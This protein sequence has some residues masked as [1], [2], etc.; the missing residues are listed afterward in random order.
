MFGWLAATAL[1]LATAGTAPEADILASGRTLVVNGVDALT[2]KTPAGGFT[3]E[4][5]I[6]VIAKALA[7][8]KKGQTVVV[9]SD[10]GLR[11]ALQGKTVATVTEAEAK[12]QGVTPAQLAELWAISINKALYVPP[13]VLPGQPIELVVG[14]LQRI[15]VVGSMSRL[16]EVKVEPSG[17]VEVTRQGFDMVLRP[18]KRGDGQIV[19]S[20]GGAFKSVL[21]SILTPAALF[22]QQFTVEVTGNPA[23]QG[24][25]LE[26]IQ[27]AMST[28]VDAE[29]KA[30]IRYTV[31][32]QSDL[33]SG[34][35]RTVQVQAEVEAPG[36][37]PV[38]G[39][40][41]VVVRNSGGGVVYDD[42]LWYSNDPENLLGPGQLYFA[43]MVTGMPTRLLW[44]HYNKTSA[45]LAVQYTL[46]NRSDSQARIWL[47]SGDGEPSADP[48]KVG[49]DAGQKYFAN[50]LG[51]QGSVLTLPSRSATPLSLRRLS[52]GQ[53]SSGLA[54][55]QLLEGGSDDVVLIGNAVNPSEIPD[56][57][58]PQ[59]FG[60]KPWLVRRSIANDRFGFPVVGQERLVFSNPAK[61]IGF[62][63][64]VGGRH[65]FIRLGE[66]GIPSAL[67][68]TPL[69]GNFG[70]QYVVE[71]RLENPT[72]KAQT[73]EIEFE[74]SAGYSGAVFRVNGKILP[75]RILQSKESV[76]LHEVKLPAG[77]AEP[78]RIDTIPL[79]GAHYPATITVRP[80]GTS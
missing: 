68:G 29:P 40:V 4:E 75:G 78:L 42:V 27:G 65:Q 72:S 16:A 36:F 30:L 63:Y 11:V 69:S 70:V 13:L 76:V 79:S 2:L 47:T 80:K 58:K 44:H 34:K 48:T 57:W 17:L 31:P 74:A 60:S 38:K 32:E 43:R 39:Q 56:E 18:L 15:R 35:I 8:F 14:Q 26:S 59:E 67:G 61:Q 19:V 45:P 28:M 53:T 21:F 7:P 37:A 6:Q 41:T 66:K 73:V 52:P 1:V 22:P 23:Q 46:V 24:L 77:G 12:A 33:G 51:H 3:P 64:Q 10:P 20:A 5:R 25:V 71:G 9:A 50:W 49:F 55:L 54:S 62:V